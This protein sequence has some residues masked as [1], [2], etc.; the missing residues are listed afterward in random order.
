MYYLA[1]DTAAALQALVSRSLTHRSPPTYPY[2]A[3]MHCLTVLSLMTL[4][5][6]LSSPLRCY[7]LLIVCLMS[8]YPE[9]K[10]LGYLKAAIIWG[11]AALSYRCYIP[12]HWV[13]VK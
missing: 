7:G 5:S 8:P 1:V 12:Y 3:A 13:L 2:L 6:L 4:F 10:A 9:A 11:N